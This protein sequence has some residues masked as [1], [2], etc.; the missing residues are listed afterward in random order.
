MTDREI[1]EKIVADGG[2]GEIACKGDLVDW[3]NYGTPCP[4][5]TGDGCIA[6][7]PLSAKQ[8]L[9]DHPEPCP[10]CANEW[11]AVYRYCPVCGRKL[12]LQEAHS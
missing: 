10:D 4:F 7:R 9:L 5:T 2:C 12:A 11:P 8:Y 3:A 1:A 6:G